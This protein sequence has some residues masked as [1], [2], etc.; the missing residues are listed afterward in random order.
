MLSTPVDRACSRA[1]ERPGEGDVGECGS[2]M[3][4]TVLYVDDDETNLLVFEATLRSSCRVLCVQGGEEALRVLEREEVAVLVTDQRMPRMTGVELLEATARGYPDVVRI[5]V[6]AYTELDAAIAAINRGQVSRYVR[7]PWTPGELRA[8]IGDA[9]E[10]HRTKVRLR[11]LERQLRETER[12]Y[13]LGVVA[14]SIAHDLRSPITVALAA[15]DLVRRTIEAEPDAPRSPGRSPGS[16]TPA[17]RSPR[18][19]RS[20]P[21]WT[22]ASAGRSPPRPR[23]WREVIRLTVACLQGAARRKGELRVDLQPVPRVVGSPTA[24]GQVVMNLLVNALEA[25]PDGGGPAA[26]VRVSLRREEACGRR[27]GRGHGCRAS[28]RR[29]S[30]RIFDPFFTTKSEGGTGLGLAI[31]QRIVDEVKGSLEVA[32]VAGAGSRFVVRLPLAPEA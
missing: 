16:R 25:L 21:A 22:R 2:A 10:H 17:R 5:L 15:I 14:A 23:T 1:A 29:P 11:L 26:R 18:S 9:L 32:S 6:T 28:P 3:P 7:K 30:R 13:A 4:D 24:L 20:W 12:V 31:S 27:R 19:A 8:V